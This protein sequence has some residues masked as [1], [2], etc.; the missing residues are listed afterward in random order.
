MKFLWAKI[1]LPKRKGT[2]LQTDIS[3]E[4][5][6][7][8][9]K[10]VLIDST[11]WVTEEEFIIISDTKAPKVEFDFAKGKEYYQGRAETDISGT[12]EPGAEVYLFI[13][14]PLL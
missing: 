14:R 3:L 8:K 6:G 2:S 7:N 9:I 10:I 11:G 1:L 13:F 5:G 4:E 12:T